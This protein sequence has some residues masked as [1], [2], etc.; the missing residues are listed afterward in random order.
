LAIVLPSGRPA[1]DILDG[2][3]ERPEDPWAHLGDPEP[4]TRLEAAIAAVGRLESGEGSSVPFLGTAFAVG[5]DLLLGFTGGSAPAVIDFRRELGSAESVLAEI[6]EVVYVD[7]RWGLSLL[8][9]R[10]PD[11][12][13]PLRLSVLDPEELTGREVVL[14][15]YPS[16]DPRNDPALVQRIFRGVLDVK[17][18]L[19]GRI[20]G[21]D[22]WN[23]GRP[24]LV[25]DCASTGG[26]GGAPLV[27][28]ASGDVV[29]IHFAGRYLENNYAVPSRELGADAK[30][31][32]A[33]VWFAGTIP[34]RPAPVVT[35]SPR[36]GGLVEVEQPAERVSASDDVAAG[37]EGV[38]EG[39]ITT[40]MRPALLVERWREELE[41]TW[42]E[43]LMPHEQRLDSAMRAVGKVLNGST[44][45]AWNGTAFVVGDRLALTAS[46]V[47]A[48]FADGGGQ[49]VSL[50][51]GRTPAVD[52]GE[53]LG[54][55]PGS[56][57]AA[58]TAIRFIHPYFN[59]ALL[60]LERVPEGIARLDL[61]AQ[62]PSQ[63]SG[64]AVVVV[65]YG[66]PPQ[67]DAPG[68]YVEP[69]GRLF[70]QPGQ[71]RQLG[72]LP[73][74]SGVPALGHDCT[75]GGG[76]AGGPVVDLETGY[77][78]GVH[79]HG[80]WFEGGWAQPTWE[81]ARDP[82]VWDFPIGFRPDPRPVWLDGWKVS[83]PASSVTPEPI[84]DARPARWTVDEVPIDWTREEPRQLEHLLA[85]TI[86]AQIALYTAE[87]VG[88]PLGMVN[89][90]APPQILWR[91]IIKTASTA[92]LLRRLLEALAS[93][94]Q[95]GGIAP[96][97]RGY[98]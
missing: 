98:L 11:T 19:P 15:G 57:T 34:V 17:R 91:E 55:P 12:V 21:E 16:S 92:A 82:V 5:G 87:N 40:T 43:Q 35:R 2:R 81:L 39:I 79:T 59:V 1:I 23:D 54:V 61:A 93:E 68:P 77:V 71:A 32:D 27:D 84:Q 73:D 47:A 96:K 45:D 90:S 66:A 78:I 80:K 94:P 50:T 22:V 74:E 76:S 24:V 48:E 89:R 29:G 70:I 31:V 86:D 44:P 13:E 10:L 69:A 49:H 58:V 42:R 28:V 6:D 56:A 46:F 25:H 14:L 41:G 20:G 52:F 53:A 65:A 95:Y 3:Y 38:L 63:L 37:P 83:A 67:G 85:Q 60:E 72:Q 8:R 62:L 18:L 33:G 26:C 97:I 36:N 64:R 75:T 9:G 88:L 30:L 4:R 7:A 51:S